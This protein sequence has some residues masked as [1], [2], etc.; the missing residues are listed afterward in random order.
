MFEALSARRAR[1][2]GQVEVGGWKVLV[3]VLDLVEIYYSTRGLAHFSVFAWAQEL[4]GRN[5]LVRSAA[6]HFLFDE[7]LDDLLRLPVDDFLADVAG[8]FELVLA[9]LG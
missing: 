4:Q 9:L 3:D 1:E 6:V 2:L 5:D 8:P 7:C